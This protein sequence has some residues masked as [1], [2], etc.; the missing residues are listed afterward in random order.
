MN[1]NGNMKEP[2]NTHEVFFF[3]DNIGKRMF[4]KQENRFNERE[5]E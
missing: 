2:I 5:K 1:G 4:N 3:G